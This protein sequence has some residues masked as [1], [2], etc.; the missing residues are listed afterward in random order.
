MIQMQ[1]WQHWEAVYYD[2]EGQLHDDWVC[3]RVRRD[4]TNTNTNS[5]EVTRAAQN[6]MKYGLFWLKSC[7]FH[8]WTINVCG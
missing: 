7:P 1:N 4:H 8:K 5:G 3:I 2:M 6:A